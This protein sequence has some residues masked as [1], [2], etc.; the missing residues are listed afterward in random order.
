LLIVF[1]SLLAVD[2]SLFL[3]PYF[4]WYTFYVH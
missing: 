3:V 4:L 1:C 2:G